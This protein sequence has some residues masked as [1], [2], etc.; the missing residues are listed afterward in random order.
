MPVFVADEMA[1]QP[2]RGWGSSLISSAVSATVFG[3]A[4]G[5]YV[6]PLLN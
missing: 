1:K 5:L 6:P 3:A 2:R 4:V